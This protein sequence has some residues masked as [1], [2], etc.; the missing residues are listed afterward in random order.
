M[1]QRLR[2]TL[3]IQLALL[4]VIVVS[5]ISLVSRILISRQFDHYVIEQQKREADDIADNIAS[6]YDISYDGWN[7]DYV[8]GMGMYAL[9]DGF[10][11]RL[12]DKEQQILWDAEHHDMSLCHD[13]MKTI[14]ERMQQ[15]RPDLEGDFVSHRYE[16][17]SAGEVIGYLEIDYY[18]PYYMNENDFQFV[19]ALNRIL[20]VIGGVG[21]L[22]AVGLGILLSN[23]IT[24]PLSEVVGVTRQISEGNY[25]IRLNSDG[26]TKEINELTD[27]VN[28]MA[29]SLTEQENLRRQLTS[30]VAHE[31]R[32]PVAN[33]SSYMEMMIDEMM[34]PTPEHLQSCYEELNRLASLISDLEQLQ[35]EET[36][37]NALELTEVELHALAETVLE[38]FESL[39]R[40]KNI[41]AEVSGDTSIL[42]ADES[43]LKQV[44]VNLISNA[45]KYSDRDGRIGIS[46]EDREECSVICVE[47]AGIGIPEEDLARIFERFYRTDKSRNRETG[48]RGIGLAIVKAIVQAHEGTIVCQSE[49]GKGS[50]FIVTLPKKND[51]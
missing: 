32:T 47:D 39:L 46:I 20:L 9:N 4:V 16:L 6:Q 27:S 38:G 19:T 7:I 13:V 3:S 15:Q 51:R 2:T 23:R 41:S 18:T 28:R 12:Y 35:S 22:A 14:T 31:L 44:L 29:A 1:R 17:T 8:H 5:L 30:D 42:H 11:I 45:I 34:E 50:R 26:K 33:L 48:G 49:N 40:D 36:A 24:N 21:L 43:K 25:N 37:G 10:I